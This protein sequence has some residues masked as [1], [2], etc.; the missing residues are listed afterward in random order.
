MAVAETFRDNNNSFLSIPRKKNSRG[1]AE[2]ET[3]M[4]NEVINCCSFPTSFT[5]TSYREY[6][7]LIPKQDDLCGNWIL[8]VNQKE[9]P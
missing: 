1:V 9:I 2:S 4:S 8:V 6:I 7:M 5:A 3:E